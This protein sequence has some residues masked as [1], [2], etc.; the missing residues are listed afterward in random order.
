MQRVTRS[1]GKSCA[2]VPSQLTLYGCSVE[3]RKGNMSGHRQ[4]YFPYG[5][6][7]FCTEDS[8][9]KERRGGLEIELVA[10]ILVFT[11]ALNRQLF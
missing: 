7:W 1:S 2:S 3:S 11:G 4:F 8:E 5:V 6:L 10:V 9:W